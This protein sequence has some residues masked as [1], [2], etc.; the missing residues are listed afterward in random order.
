MRLILCGGGSGEQNTKANQKLSET[1]LGRF[2]TPA[3]TAKL[4]LFLLSDD[5]NFI[6]EEKISINGGRF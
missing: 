4:C 1:P 5:S 3:D 6:T 2:A